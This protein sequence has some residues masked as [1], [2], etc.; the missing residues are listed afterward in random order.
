VNL[1]AFSTQNQAWF[2]NVPMFLWGICWRAGWLKLW[3]TEGLLPLIDF[4]V[5]LNQKRSRMSTSS[6]GISG[7]SVCEYGKCSA[8]KKVF[9]EPWSLCFTE[10]LVISLQQLSMS[11]RSSLNS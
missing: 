11:S 1:Q 5:S 6:P 8:E 9:N 3:G 4:P 7:P 10:M 2:A